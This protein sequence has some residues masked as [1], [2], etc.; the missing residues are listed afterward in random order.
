MYDFQFHQL[1]KTAIEIFYSITAFCFY[2]ALFPN[3]LLGGFGPKN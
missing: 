1:K 2:L 3:M